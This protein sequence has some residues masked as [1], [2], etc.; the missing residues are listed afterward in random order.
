MRLVLCIVIC[1]ICVHS[2]ISDR[3]PDNSYVW[4]QCTVQVQCGYSGTVTV[5]Y[6]GGGGHK[7]KAGLILIPDL[8]L[9]LGGLL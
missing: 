7:Y 1:V 6:P 8:A 4:V 5:L 9:A 3:Y 2:D